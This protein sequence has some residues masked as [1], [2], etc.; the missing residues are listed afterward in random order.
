MDC[1]VTL[2]TLYPKERVASEPSAKYLAFKR[3]NHENPFLY[4]PPSHWIKSQGLIS[5]QTIKALAP[6]PPHFKK[7]GTGTRVP[8]VRLRFRN[9]GALAR[10]SEEGPLGTNY[11]KTFANLTIQA[12]ECIRECSC[13][14]RKQ[15]DW[16][17][18]S[19]SPI[20]SILVLKQG[21]L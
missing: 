10:R 6:V 11:K 18:E 19:L 17:S 13:V 8:S 9:S 21:H 2:N 1:Q 7:G 14:N 16:S 20:L 15:R 4:S 12:R 3:G 5:L